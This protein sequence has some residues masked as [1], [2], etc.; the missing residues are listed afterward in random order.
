MTF[1]K[2]KTLQDMGHGRNLEEKEQF[3]YH[4]TPAN[5]RVFFVCL[6]VCLFVYHTFRAT[7]VSQCSGYN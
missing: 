3:Y 5:P 4:S 2:H 1:M 7:G 6:F